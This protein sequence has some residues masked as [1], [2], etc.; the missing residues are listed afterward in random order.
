MILSFLTQTYRLSDTV[1]GYGMN[2]DDIDIM[3]KKDVPEIEDSPLLAAGN[4]S[5][6]LLCTFYIAPAQ[7][8]AR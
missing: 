3:R 2:T 1:P 6:W 8:A 5:S 7:W 4:P